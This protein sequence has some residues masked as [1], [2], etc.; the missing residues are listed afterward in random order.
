VK[1]ISGQTVSL[2]RDNL[3]SGVYFIRLT[4]EKKI[5]AVEKLIITH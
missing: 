2:S 1:N 3:P 5:I 4:E